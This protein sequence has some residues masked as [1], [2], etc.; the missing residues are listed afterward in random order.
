MKFL[1]STSHALTTLWLLGK[2]EPGTIMKTRELSEALGASEASLGKILLQL[3]RKGIVKSHRGPT[4]G[5]ELLVSPEELSVSR[6]LEACDDPRG[7]GD[8]CVMGLGDCSKG[9]ECVMHEPWR[10]FIRRSLAQIR[11]LTLAN[12]SE[13]TCEGIIGKKIKRK[14]ESTDMTNLRSA[15]RH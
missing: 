14:I 5:F 12:I 3:S 4:G 11:Q 15:L 1:Q 2:Q 7:W 9:S 10:R 6:I 13:R 8:E